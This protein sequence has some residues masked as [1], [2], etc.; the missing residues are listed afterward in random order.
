LNQVIA[1]NHFFDGLP[2]AGPLEESCCWFLGE[3]RKYSRHGL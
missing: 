1:P 2:Q 3:S